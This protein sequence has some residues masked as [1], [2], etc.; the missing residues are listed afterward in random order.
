MG[1]EKEELFSLEIGALLHDLGKIGVP[2]SILFKPGPLDDKEYE[3]V[4]E[5][6]QRGKKMIEG[7]AYLE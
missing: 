5:H 3:Q 4:K 2:D 7:I 1:L 6:P